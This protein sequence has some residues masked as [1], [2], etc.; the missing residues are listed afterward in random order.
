MWRFC[1]VGS[2]I[3]LLLLSLQYS[4]DEVRIDVYHALYP[5]ELHVS[6]QSHSAKASDTKSPLRNAV[7]TGFI[8]RAGRLHKDR[9]ASA[10]WKLDGGAWQRAPGGMTVRADSSW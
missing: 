9:R 1:K 6:Q 5:K 7:W 4:D 8:L 2:K 10:R 3:S